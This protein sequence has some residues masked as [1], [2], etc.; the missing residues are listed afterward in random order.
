MGYWQAMFNNV[1]IPLL[2]LAALFGQPLTASAQSFDLDETPQ[3]VQ[4]FV[5]ANLLATF[6]HELGHALIDILE[7]PVF[8]QEEDAAD[9]A[10]TLMID[11]LYEEDAARALAYDT[12]FGFLGEAERGGEPAWWD[13]HGPDQQR[14]Y[15]I[16]CLFYGANPDERE[17]LAEEM[18]LPEER[19]ETCPEEFDLAQASWGPVW[20]ELAENAPGNSI[21]PPTVSG[22]SDATVFT[23][24]VIGI[25]LD[26]LNQDFVLPVKLGVA[27]EPCGEPNA[28]YD[29]DADL[30]I[31][32]TE[33]AD[34]LV[35]LAPTE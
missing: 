3:A 18:G 33:F 24:N 11:A 6:Y 9:V 14:Y 1:A 20:D 31:M 25:E 32:Y 17:D 4:D 22:N 16:V 35:G 7:L 5:E 28:F 12:A 23:E 30:I 19:A 10:S 26:A 21:G 8:G 29:P 2:L 15:N 34:Y 27:I 13:T